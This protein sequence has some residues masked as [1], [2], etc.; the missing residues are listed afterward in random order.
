ME[1]F[2]NAICVEGTARNVTCC[3]KL[4]MPYFCNDQTLILD[5]EGSLNDYYTTQG[6]ES[7]GLR[8]FMLFVGL[9]ELK[10]LNS[11]SINIAHLHHQ[12]VSFLVV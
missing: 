1:S 3:C 6:D 4:K 5:T 2:E 8:L 7:T 10:R 9:T 12:I 11:L